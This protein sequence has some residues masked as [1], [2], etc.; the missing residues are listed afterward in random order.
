[1][2]KMIPTFMS[3]MIGAGLSGLVF[4]FQW[5]LL[6]IEHNGFSYIVPVILGSL[7]GII[8]FRMKIRWETEASQ[9]Q[10][11]RLK[12]VQ[13]ISGAMCHEM[14]QPLQTLLGH[15]DIL[16]ME[17]PADSSQARDILEQME[18]DIFRIKSITHKM[19]NLQQYRTKSYL[20]GQILD[21][22]QSPP[23]GDPNED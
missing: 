11:D 5:V 23:L 12:T 15:V 21:I 16:K 10:A 14:S 4:A 18:R 9:S 2:K 6:G 19:E 20:S 17:L 7:I 22:N 13:E 3:G 8:I 1:M